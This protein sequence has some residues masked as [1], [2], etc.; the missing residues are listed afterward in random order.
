[1]R[2]PWLNAACDFAE[3]FFWPMLIAILPW[4]AGFRVARFVARRRWFFNSDATAAFTI[5]K[6]RLQLDDE[7]DWF[8]RYCFTRLID[9][10]DLYLSLT[11]NRAWVEKHLAYHGRWP[12]ESPFIGMTFHWGNGLL[13]LRS[14]Q[15]AA[16]PFSGVAIAVDKAA[17]RGRPVL[18]AYVKIRNWE[19]GRAIGG[20][21]NYTGSAAR[22][23]VAALQEAK[24]ICGLFDVPPTPSVKTRP[25]PFLGR[26][27]N[28][29]RGAVRLATAHK[30]PL[31]IFRST[32]DPLNG[33]LGSPSIISFT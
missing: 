2:S 21:L 3:L 1:M 27:A 20:G 19:T 9:H 12:A 16:G 13:A 26:M 18:Y 24:S 22:R 23:F 11:R 6:T 33:R 29:P 15:H 31:V 32:V 25:A 4:P 7:S 30:V 10:A 14:M 5:A 17:F 8:Y 28:F